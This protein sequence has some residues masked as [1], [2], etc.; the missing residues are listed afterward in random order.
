M[1]RLALVNERPPLPHKCRI[2]RVKSVV[3]SRRRAGIWQNVNCS[4]DTKVSST[5]FRNLE[6]YRIMAIV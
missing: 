6:H 4:T 1:S 2:S 3:E 5:S